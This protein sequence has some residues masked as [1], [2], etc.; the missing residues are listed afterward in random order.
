M[1]NNETINEWETLNIKCSLC[2]KNFKFEVPGCGENIIK[3]NRIHIECPL[4]KEEIVINKTNTTI[5]QRQ[6]QS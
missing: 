2:N 3:A 4:C 6:V 1:K 5:S